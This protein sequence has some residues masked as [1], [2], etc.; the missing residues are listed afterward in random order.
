MK[1]SKAKLSKTKID[2]MFRLGYKL[3]FETENKRKRW[4]DIVALLYCAATNGH[5]RAQ[6]YLAT[7]YDNGLG[8]G[9]NL[10]LA[11]DW[12]LK[13]AKTGH[14]ES[15]YNVG[16]FFGRDEIQIENHKT[17]IYWYKR[18]ANAGHIGAQR[19]LGYSYFYGKGVKKDMKRAVLW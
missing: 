8:T 14:R 7:C 2:K 13:A 9:K 11:F 15:Q 18:A 19:D 17:K 6:F 3:A 12:Y 4:R 16:F 10:Q 5:T 1:D